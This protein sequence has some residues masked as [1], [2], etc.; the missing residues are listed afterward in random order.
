M[1]PV[2]DMKLSHMYNLVNLLDL[3]LENDWENIGY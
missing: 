3:N 2:A 1:M